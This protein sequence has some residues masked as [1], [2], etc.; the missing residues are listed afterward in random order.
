MAGINSNLFED[1]KR[2][3]EEAK[4]LVKNKNVDELY[5]ME[6]FSLVINQFDKLIKDIEKIIKISDGQQEYLHRIQN[7]LKREIEDRIRAEEKLKYFAAIDTLTGVYN[8]GMGLTFLENEMKAIRRKK[9]SFSV[10]Y[11]DVNGLKHVNDNFGHYEGDELLVLICKFI[12]EVIREKDI[13]CR[14]GGDEFFILL[15][16][17]KKEEAEEIIKKIILNIDIENEK[18]PRPYVISFSYGI[19]EVESDNNK[20][21]DEIM[22]LADAKM[23]EY[24]QSYKRLY[25]DSK[26]K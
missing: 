5:V 16:N 17:N 12:R 19:V 2:L 14:L 13:L 3:L 22:Q 23:Y 11:I 9:E 7:D 6:E 1:E 20:S 21:I 15:P 26:Y 18:R 25:Q 8:R 24:K 4:T 10:C